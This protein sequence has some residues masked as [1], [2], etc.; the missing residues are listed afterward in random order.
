MLP[1]PQPLPPLQPPRIE[2]MFQ[3]GQVDRWTS[4]NVMVSVRRKLETEK[5]NTMSGETMELIETLKLN[6]AT[7][8]EKLSLTRDFALRC[9]RSKAPIPQ[10]VMK[11]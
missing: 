6:E 4:K 9:L 10:T 3:G 1:I 11:I 7:T 2:E 8:D 5:G